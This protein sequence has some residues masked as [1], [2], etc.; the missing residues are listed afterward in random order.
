MSLHSPQV[1]GRTPV[2]KIGV[3]AVSSMRAW[4]THAAEDGASDVLHVGK[5]WYSV[6]KDTFPR[7]LLV[8]SGLL[9]DHSDLRRQRQPDA[10][11]HWAVSLFDPVSQQRAWV[12]ALP[13]PLAG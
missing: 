2:S 7:C 8:V 11:Q 12:A 10:L 13:L 6:D 3:R 5:S 9:F 4:G 1:Y